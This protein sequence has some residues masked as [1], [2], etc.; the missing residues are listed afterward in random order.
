MIELSE[1]EAPLYD[2]IRDNTVEIKENKL[3]GQS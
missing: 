3:F 1:S 2:P